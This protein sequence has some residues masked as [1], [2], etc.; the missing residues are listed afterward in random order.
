MVRYGALLSAVSVLSVLLS[1]ASKFDWFREG[2]KGMEVRQGPPSVRFYD[3]FGRASGRYI[4]AGANLQLF[5][6]MRHL[7]L[8]LSSTR[9]SRWV[10]FDNYCGSLEEAHA[11]NGS[12]MAA[13]VLL[14]V[15]SVLLPN[16]LDC[17]DFGIVAG[18]FAFPLSERKPPN[19]VDFNVAT[20]TI[21]LQVD[22]V[23]RICLHTLIFVVFLPA[24]LCIMSEH[25]VPRDGSP[26]E[27]AVH[28]SGYTSARTLHLCVALVFFVDLVRRHTAQLSWICNAPVL[29][30]WAVDRVWGARLLALAPKAAPDPGDT[31]EQGSSASEGGPLVEVAHDAV[32]GFWAV[33]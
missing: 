17:W 6:R 11:W 9:L 10:S 27:D 33:S 13:L 4:L 19:F 25:Q 30:L 22:D 3:V 15:W 7:H 21:S 14:H 24:T 32:M 16:L 28:P 18:E 23:V 12:A 2:S 8:W 5:F 31:S 20:E 26:G 29:F 1:V